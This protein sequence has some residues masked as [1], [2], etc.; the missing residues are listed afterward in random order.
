[1]EIE[2]HLSQSFIDS[3]SGMIK[4]G[5]AGEDHSCT[6]F[7]FFI[8]YLSYSN[9]IVGV[10]NS[11]NEHADFQKAFAFSTFIIFF[12]RLFFFQLNRICFSVF[13]VLVNTIFT[14]SKPRVVII[15]K[16]LYFILN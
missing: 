15:F 5:L 6:V 7:L 16:T 3:G 2:M 14:G 9:Q 4:A 11:K 10:K 12:L 13:M 8:V 1:M